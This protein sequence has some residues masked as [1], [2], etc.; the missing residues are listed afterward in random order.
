[1]D[2]NTTN[3]FFY[4]ILNLDNFNIININVSLIMKK[5]LTLVAIVSMTSCATIFTGTSESITFDSNVKGAKVLFD[6]VE[7]GKTPHTQKV[8]KSFNGIVTMKADGYETKTFELMKSFNAISI[9]NLGG[10]WG[11]AIDFATGAINKFDRKGYNMEL[12]KEKE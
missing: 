1:M 12:D 5:I 11:W 3:F 2:N 4:T 10:I 7:V 8:K 9:L 6:G